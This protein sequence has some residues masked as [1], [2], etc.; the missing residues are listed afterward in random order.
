MFNKLLLAIM[1]S[2]SFAVYSVGQTVSVSD[3][4]TPLSICNG[5]EP[6]EE[7]D[8]AMSLYDYNGD[9]NGGKYYVIHIDLAA[10]W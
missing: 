2:F 4:Q 1:F 9:F 7:N 6:N 8:G 5:H 3:Q 10:S